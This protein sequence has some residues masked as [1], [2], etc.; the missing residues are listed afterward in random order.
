MPSLPFALH[1][2]QGLT[3]QQTLDIPDFADLRWCASLD[4]LQSSP[5]W[6]VARYFRCGY[7]GDTNVYDHG[8]CFFDTRDWRDHGYANALDIWQDPD[9]DRDCT[10]ATVGTIHRI[11]G[12][13]DLKDFRDF[14]HD[15]LPPAKYPS[16]VV[17]LEHATLLEISYCK[18]QYGVEPDE[19]AIAYRF[20]KEHR[21]W[22]TIWQLLQGLGPTQ[23]AV[24]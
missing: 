18:G 20:Y 24:E 12:L 10:C 4:Q 15:C 19:A 17:S 3:L 7:E 13:E 11:T 6:D 22:K 8:G 5:A 16:G 23:N 21:M 2:V 14:M 9:S 1:R